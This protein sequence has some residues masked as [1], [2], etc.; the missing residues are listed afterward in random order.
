M[1]F[2]GFYMLISFFIPLTPVE[3][4]TWKKSFPDKV[5]SRQYK[6]GILPCQD[7]TFYMLSQDVIYEE[8][9]TLPGSLQNETEFYPG[10]PLSCNHHLREKI[11]VF[12]NDSKTI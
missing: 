11:S 3:A 2:Y 7:E 6:G 9:I 8:F 1:Y 5:G 10:Y 4:I 12:S